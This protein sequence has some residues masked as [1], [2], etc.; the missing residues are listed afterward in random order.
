MKRGGVSQEIPNRP[1]HIGRSWFY[2]DPMRGWVRF[3][4]ALSKK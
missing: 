1:V 2:E 4:R 3:Y